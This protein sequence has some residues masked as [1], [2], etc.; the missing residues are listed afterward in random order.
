M[1]DKKT[2][3]E[4]GVNELRRVLL[5][6][7]LISPYITENDKYP[8]WDGELIVKKNPT[9]NKKDIDFRVPVQVKSTQSDPTGK[10][11]LQIV[12][13]EKYRKDGGSVLFVVYLDEKLDLVDI[14]YRSLTP[15][16]IDEILFSIN[17][18]QDTLSI[19]IFKI[20]SGR[21]LNML[22]NFY[23]RKEI[24]FSHNKY[25]LVTIDDLEEGDVVKYDIYL[26]EDFGVFQFQKEHGLSPYVEKKSGL[27]LPLAGKW[28]IPAYSVLEKSKEI[29]IGKC[30]FSNYE[31]IIME[32]EIILN[33]GKGFKFI[34]YKTDFKLK[35]SIP[36]KISDAIESKEIL[37][38][39]ISTGTIYIDNKEY[40]FD[41]SQQTN[42][43]IK[44][45]ELNI[46]NLKKIKKILK[47]LDV[48]EELIVSKFDEK[49][50]TSLN[51]L[52]EGISSKK[53]L[54]IGFK[55]TALRNIH[56]ANLNFII[57]YEE[58]GEKQ[59]RL[60]D[61]FKEGVDVWTKG[62]GIDEHIS[63]FERLEPQD[64]ISISRYDFGR[65]IKSYDY[66]LGNY[67]NQDIQSINNLIIRLMFAYDICEDLSRKSML[68]NW[69]TELF[70]Y[71]DINLKNKD[72]SIYVINKLQ[73]KKRVE[74]LDKEDAR[75]LNEILLKEKE[76]IHFQFTV[77]TLLES[78]MLAELA[79]DEFTNEE[80]ETYKGYPIYNLYKEL[81]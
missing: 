19:D 38:D 73:F 78:K 64:W 26:G 15:F 16:V 56:I 58:R 72:D 7:N 60:I 75:I 43:N 80:Q 62:E 10:F 5:K 22:R 79:W 61:V 9:S 33:V 8:I 44:E 18:R 76:N 49:A 6:T 71:A 35:Y 30:I 13:L 4:S 45:I 39:F 53:N 81:K 66:I 63:I 74:K 51:I 77:N 27:R 34:F 68:K 14:Y 69:V 41:L 11:S 48:K 1:Y 46:I 50:A 17:K 67:P 29:K 70:K 52:Y 32:D 23:K 20:K 65:I 55:G 12:D 21:I 59:G 3:E 24:E 57:I 36:D 47:E 28:K 40:N 31:K 37:R 42:F 2:V 54:K 25:N